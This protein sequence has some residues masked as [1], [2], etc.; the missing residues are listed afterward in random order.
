MDV[1]KRETQIC[2]IDAEGTV[3]LEQRIRTER[4][5]FADVVGTRH[6]CFG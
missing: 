4:R 5:R 2:I 6:A 3:V 1:H